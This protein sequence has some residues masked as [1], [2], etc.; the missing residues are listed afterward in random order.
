[1]AP[2]LG[3]FLLAPLIAEFLLGNVPFTMLAAVLFLAPMYGAGAVLIR[4]AARHTGRGWPTI[5]LLAAGYGLLEAGLLDESLFNPTFEGWDFQSVAHVPVLGISASSLLT[6]V[7]GH[8]IWSIGI[9][10]LLVETL[11]PGPTR[12]RCQEPWLGRTGLAVTAVV[13]VLGC[14]LIFREERGSTGF[15]A[16][17]GQLTG[18]AVVI[19]VLWTLAFTVRRSSGDG[20][21]PP[22]HPAPGPGL[23]GAA[24]LIASGSFFG[25]PESW[26]GVVL[27]GTLLLAATVAVLR[28]S[29]RPGWSAGHRFALAAGALPTYMWGGFVLLRLAGHDTPV[30]LIGQGILVLG[31]VV[32]LLVAGRRV[33][34][35]GSPSVPDQPIDVTTVLGYPLADRL[36]LLIGLPGLGLLIGGVLPTLARWLVGL[37]VGLPVRPVFL[38]LSSVDQPWELALELAVWLTIGLVL[39]L[40][41]LHD[42]TRVTLTDDRLWLSTDHR[43]RTIARSEV[44]Q[45]FLDGGQLVV[46]DAGLRPLARE[47]PQADARMLG[48]AFQRHGYPWREV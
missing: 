27:G 9:P 40:L 10:I 34:S 33:R 39:T 48:Q 47:K 1:M 41:A 46:L 17:P 28:W 23:V 29:R 42:L 2:V 43:V 21:R 11:A 45:V 12:G 19:G 8:V 5:V 37:R 26:P 14:L 35:G 16:A 25:R 31:A 38:L 4:E 6:F 44:G 18:T 30:N 20:R 15:L 3:L 24:S 13:F 36:V 32:L 7:A 22:E